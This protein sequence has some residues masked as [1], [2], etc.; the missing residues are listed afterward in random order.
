MTRLLSSPILLLSD[1]SPFYASPPLSPFSFITIF[2]DYFLSLIPLTLSP[3]SSLRFEIFISVFSS[4][5]YA[6]SHYDYDIAS[7]TC[8]FDDTGFHIFHFH[9]LQ[10]PPFIFILIRH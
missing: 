9:L 6:A 3:A 4:I 8:H 1:F 7:D 5:D 10:L 2:A